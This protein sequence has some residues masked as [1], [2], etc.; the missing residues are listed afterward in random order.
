MEKFSE[1]LQ[2]LATQLDTTVEHVM[3][4]LVKQATYDAINSLILSTIAILLFIVLA[5]I[6]GKR[7]IYYSHLKET[8]PT[9]GYGFLSALSVFASLV[10]C[11]EVGDSIKQLFNPEFGAYKLLVDLLN[12]L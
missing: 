12:N 9:V 4:I 6:T 1:L 5:L 11:T 7:S 2:I 10:A 8:D 3:E